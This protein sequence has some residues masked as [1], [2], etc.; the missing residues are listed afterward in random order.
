MLNEPASKRSITVKIGAETAED[1]N[2]L[3]GKLVEGNSHASR[4]IA[5]KASWNQKIQAILNDYKKFLGE[6]RNEQTP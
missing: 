4:Q 1:V 5:E 6:G 3:F 2:A